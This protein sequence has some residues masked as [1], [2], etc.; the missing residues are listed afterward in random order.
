MF[1]HMLVSLVQEEQQ[2][3]TNFQPSYSKQTVVDGLGGRF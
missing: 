3:T 1:A 2:K